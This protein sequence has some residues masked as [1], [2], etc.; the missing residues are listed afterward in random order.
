[1]K[2]TNEYYL[3][4]MSEFEGSK[5]YQLSIIGEFSS[6]QQSDKTKRRNEVTKFTAI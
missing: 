3:K 6:Q 4:L 5:L 2:V 1:M